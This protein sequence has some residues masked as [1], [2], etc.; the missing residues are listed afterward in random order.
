MLSNNENDS[1]RFHFFSFLL[2]V[3]YERI[4]AQERDLLREM[5]NINPDVSGSTRGN[6]VTDRLR[7][8]LEELQ[9]RNRLLEQERRSKLLTFDRYVLLIRILFV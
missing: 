2:F 4:Q 5:Y 3:Q 7:A 9:R 1:I 6:N 8:Q